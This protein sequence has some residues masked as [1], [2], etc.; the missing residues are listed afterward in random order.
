MTDSVAF[1]D[2]VVE[3]EADMVIS[4]SVG[5]GVR[6]VMDPVCDKVLNFEVEPVTLFLSPLGL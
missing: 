5:A 2:R 3:K 4:S 1:R 6:P